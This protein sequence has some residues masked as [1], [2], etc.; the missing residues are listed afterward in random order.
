V[1]DQFK[2]HQF[3]GLLSLSLIWL[4]GAV[5]DRIWFALD[6][7]VPAWDQAEYLTG[8]LNY[9]QALQHPQWF[10]SE[11]W[12]S[13]WMLS[14][15]VPPLTFI[16][17][18]IVQNI[19][20]TGPDQA[21]LVN[22]LFSGILLGS[23]YGLGVQLFSVEVGLWAAGLC[24]I[25]PA[26]Y[27]LRLDFLLDY[28]LTAVVTL[29][30]WCLT[31][32]KAKGEGRRR[33]SGFS[34]SGMRGEGR[35]ARGEGA[36]G[37]GGAGGDSI[38][39]YPSS[40]QGWFWAAAFGL[41]FGLA[42]LVK[43]TA[44]FFLLVPVIW[45]GVEAI[46]K[47][48]WRRISQLVVALLLSVVVFGPWYRTN[49]L[50]IITGGKR[51][52][53][54]AA[55]AEGDP[56]LN[57]LAAWTYYWELLPDQVSW[58][59][60]LVPIVVTLLYWTRARILENPSPLAP[61]PSPLI[62]LTVF[63]LGSYLLCS[64]NINKDDRY[65]LPYL[66]VVSLFLA[67]GLTRW[68]GRWG[69]R[70]RW[71]TAGL[72]VLLMFFNLFPVGGVLGNG[73][74]Q[75]LSPNAQY[76]AYLKPELPHTQVID[77]IIQTE[78]YI[79]STLGVLPSTPEVNQHNFN[80][81]GAL[82]DFQVFARQVGTQKKQIF[83]D[84]RSLDWFLTKTGNQGSVP[85]AQAG[86]VQ[87]VEQGGDFQLHKTWS[88]PDSSILK[89][90]HRRQPSVQVN[91]AKGV[92]AGLTGMSQSPRI[93]SSNPPL[94]DKGIVLSRVTVP[95]QAPPGVPLPVTYEWSGSWE[96]LQPGLVLLTWK[97]QAV[98][99]L[100]HRWLHDHGIGRGTLHSRRVSAEPSATE[101]R[102]IEQIAM[103][104]PADIP[105]ATY[106]LEATYL[107][108]KT[109]ETYPISVPPVTLKID[110][111]ATATPAPELDLLT[112][113][114]LL[115]ATLPQ[116]REALDRVFAEVGR[117]N[118][119]DPIQDYLVQMQLAMEYRLQR[120]PQNRAWAYALALSQVLQQHVQGAIA[121]LERVTQL[122]SQNSYAYA[123]L[124]FVHL[125]NWDGAAAEAAL[126]PALALNPNQPELQALNGIATLMQGNLIKAWHD[127]SF[128]RNSLAPHP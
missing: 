70:I 39:I 99:T 27:R 20:G 87:I 81:Y 72:A 100:H 71:G 110:P 75:A 35:G 17:T 94:H 24:Q 40:F 95:Q 22:L 73:I 54:D 66:P 5:G 16:V 111:V 15:K 28:P 13:F 19:F 64:L 96:Q 50:L 74:T 83:Q 127:L 34:K 128:L 76:H 23:V 48:D 77:E 122:D 49:W 65:V 26:L 114:R 36:G 103:L 56:P 33:A 86:I 11:W 38:Y 42:L 41:S 92:G 115:A 113:H 14:A 91:L 107:N 116:G 6:H 25:L 44:L 18:A 43:Q 63:L 58:L 32:W 84:A 12:T 126:K 29:S 125:Y 57:T 89:L 55:I 80:Y 46:R 37:A 61:R 68:F 106:T 69:N 31:V 67:Y 93:N 117:I 123:Y 85:E 3:R 53:V 78:P 104:P 102:V 120:E 88:L 60:L 124:A 98:P 79:S 118:Q 121:A 112:Q 62:W 4:I 7:S 108:R 59:L 47:R 1:S 45:V 2:H 119:Y 101:F 97:N 109:G 30:F 21:T 82:Q 8:S 51:A 10:S 90:Y 52:T 9:W 105:S